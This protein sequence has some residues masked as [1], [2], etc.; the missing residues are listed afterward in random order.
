MRN[1]TLRYTLDLSVVAH[2]ASVPETFIRPTRSGIP[3]W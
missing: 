1:L 3:R 2:V